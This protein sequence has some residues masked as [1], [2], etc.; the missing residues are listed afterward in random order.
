MEEADE[1]LFME[2]QEEDLSNK[3]WGW[4]SWRRSGS[5]LPD[6]LPRLVNFPVRVGLGRKPNLTRT[7][8]SCWNVKWN[9]LEKDLPNYYVKKVMR[10]KGLPSS[11]FCFCSLRSNPSESIYLSLKPRVTREL[12]LKEKEQGFWDGRVNGPF[13]FCWWKA[14]LTGRR[15]LVLS[16]TRELQGARHY[17]SNYGWGLGKAPGFCLFE[18]PMPVIFS[19]DL[20]GPAKQQITKKNRRKDASLENLESQLVLPNPWGHADSSSSSLLLFIKILVKRH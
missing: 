7:G 11:L 5:S 8:R 3:S 12:G 2:T 19:Q 9:R 10:D 6:P 15:P 17:K 1:I 20:T 4:D 18:R 14:L 16:M 13:V